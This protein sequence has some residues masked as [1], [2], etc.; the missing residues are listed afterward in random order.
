MV[1]VDRPPA[2]GF[3]A[4]VRR[5]Y[6]PIGFCKGYNFVLWVISAGALL[7]FSLARLMY[8]DF[9]NIFC[10]EDQSRANALPGECFYYQSTRGRVGILLHLGAILPAC[11][12][13]VLQ[14][15]PVI[16]HKLI[17]FH[18]IN[19]YVVILASFIGMAGVLMIA[20]HSFGGR[21]DT[22]IAIGL[23][24]IIFVGSISIAYWNIKRLQIEQHRAW[25]I[26]AW[27]VGGFIITMRVIGI[28]TDK[29]LLALGPEGYYEARPCAVIDF[30]FS[31]NQSLV[32]SVHPDCEAFYSGA[33]T[34]RH[35]LV[36]AFGSHGSGGVDQ[37]SAGL[38]LSFGAAAWLAVAIH[39]FAAELYLH[40][41]PA[42]AA[43]LRRVSYQR[44]L[45][46]G[47][48]RPGNAG[49]TAERLGDAEPF[50]VPGSSQEKI[51][52]D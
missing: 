28:I 29:V 39:V 50:S 14:F 2:N 27:V 42:E 41:T 33:D 16:R 10:P 6:N 43:R 17:L 13:A 21:L 11:I 8:L 45:E 31:G 48:R 15:V 3:V 46:A 1:K 7:G 49:L 19:G 24:T 22:Q 40:L 34:G 44:Q 36:D 18:R 23:A 26:R 4:V 32:E 9:D 51:V 52:C 38:N 35:V 30:M 37:A 25:M 20:E 47:M 12:L 5:I